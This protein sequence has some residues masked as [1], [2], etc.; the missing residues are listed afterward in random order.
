[1][2]YFISNNVPEYGLLKCLQYM[3]T[4]KTYEV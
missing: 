1:M 2:I 4:H 3:N